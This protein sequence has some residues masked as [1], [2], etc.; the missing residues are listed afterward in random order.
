METITVQI[1]NP[2][3]ERLLR[4]LFTDLGQ[5]QTFDKIRV[6]Q[7]TKRLLQMEQATELNGLLFTSEVRGTPDVSGLP[8]LPVERGHIPAGPAEGLT[9]FQVG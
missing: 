6:L 9:P 5:L 2:D 3:V 1:T 4:F 7:A 8:P